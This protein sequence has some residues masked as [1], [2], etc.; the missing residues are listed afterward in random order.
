MGTG[1]LLCQLSKY[2]YRVD[3]ESIRTLMSEHVGRADNRLCHEC[4]ANGLKSIKP[5]GQEPQP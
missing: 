4:F 2:L 3:W 1:F 5:A